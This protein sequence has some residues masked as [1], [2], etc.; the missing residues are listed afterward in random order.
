MSLKL[1]A[2]VL[3]FVIYAA[4]GKILS[5]NIGDSCKYNIHPLLNEIKYRKRT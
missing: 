1:I 2:C 3:V 4:Y 5:N